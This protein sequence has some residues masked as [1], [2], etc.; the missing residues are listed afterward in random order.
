MIE[1]TICYF[2]LRAKLSGAV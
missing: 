1:M 2:M